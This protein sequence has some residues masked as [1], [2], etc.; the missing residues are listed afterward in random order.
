MG[1][2]T[3][4]LVLKG[5]TIFNAILLSRIIST[6]LQKVE[7]TL[8]FQVTNL[9]NLDT[10]V[11]KG[12][13]LIDFSKI[14]NQ[15][16]LYSAHQ[17]PQIDTRVILQEYRN[18]LLGLQS[19]SSVQLSPKQPVDIYLT[20]E[21]LSSEQSDRF[22]NPIHPSSD[23][24]PQIPNLADPRK[25]YDNVVLG[26]TFDRL[27]TGH[28]V[29]LSAA[30]LRCR[31]TLTVGVTDGP[32]LNTKKLFELIEPFNT[33]SEKLREFLM[34][35]EPRLQYKI[36]PIVDPYG[37]TAEDPNLEVSFEFSFI[38]YRVVGKT[39]ILVTADAGS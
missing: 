35:I 22:E 17:A 9:K 18:T 19:D 24:Q 39:I 14:I 10:D 7:Q 31:K 4:F 20:E 11:E 3:G 32:M 8:Y 37:P 38:F 27:H 5:P 15:I 6:A 1:A 21:M 25:I 26:G 30:V 28:K 2:A 13:Q 33:R 36:V 12:N 23:D 34:D 29:L 16:Y